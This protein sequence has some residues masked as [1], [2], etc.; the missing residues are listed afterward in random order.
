[1]RPLPA[2]PGRRRSAVAERASARHVPRSDRLHARSDGHSDRLRPERTARG[3]GSTAPPVE[4]PRQR[5]ANL[6]EGV[7]RR[8]EILRSI[9]DFAT[10]AAP[11]RLFT[12]L[13]KEPVSWQEDGPNEAGTYVVSTYREIVALLHDPRI[14][15]DF[16]KGDKSGGPRTS[17]E[18]YSFIRLDPP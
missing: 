8:E 7:M 12:E 2:R 11:Y 6:K 17:M 16:S 1:G 4:A 15:S 3:V 5:P 10:R 18:R 9:S 13:R 14:S